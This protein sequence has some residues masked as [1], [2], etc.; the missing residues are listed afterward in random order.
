VLI[1]MVAAL[2]IL[3][4]VLAILG[5]RVNALSVWS[6]FPARRR[7]APGPAAAPHGAWYRIS[8][9]VMR[10][11]GK[12]LVGTLLPLLIV[13]LPFLHINFTVLDPRSL[14]AS[15]ESREVHD[16]MAD[17]FP[18]NETQPI[19]LVVRS[20]SPAL[21][22]I[23]LAALYDYTRQVAKL[24]GVRR[25]DSLVNLDPRLDKEGYIRLYSPAGRAQAPQL[26]PVIDRLSRDRYT[27]VS[28]L[29]D[30]EPYAEANRELVREIRAIEPPPGLKVTVGGEPAY[31]VDFLQSLAS[32]VPLA[33][34]LIVTVMFV[35]LFAMLGSLVVP[36]KAVV[37]NLLSLSV[38]FGALVWI[39]QDG[40]LAGPLH[41][42]P[43][44][45]V[46][47]A[48]P[49]LM[50]AGAF[51][52]SMDYQVFLLSRIKEQYDRTGDVRASVAL[53]IQKT[54]AIITSAAVLLA[55]VIGGFATGEVLF[56]KQIG[57]GL[58]LAILVD[59][60]IVRSLLVPATMRLM[61]KY[62]WWAPAPLKALHER[63][64]LG[65]PPEPPD[66]AG[67]APGPDAPAMAQPVLPRVPVPA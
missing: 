52:L 42:T 4:A 60:T 25:V 21:D 3:P 53:G 1:A 13:G 50:F 47:A 5:R 34:G 55:V 54:G 14:P 43:L 28:V 18:P 48:Q 46:D 64:G 38:S 51:G 15:H 16:V 24:D 49:V 63:L 41:F 22:S 57:V 66:P 10:H 45:S 9:L 11:P 23:S 39:F 61:G 20:S 56:I 17:V 37:L 58:A 2:T 6:I 35:I 12:V 33:F 36:V 29:Y 19:Q 7:P 62:N 40:H 31:L 8:E 27:V 30:G 67:D 59:A 65:E 26:Q 32:D 44:G